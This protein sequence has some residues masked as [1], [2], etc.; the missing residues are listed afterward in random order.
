MLQ[1]RIAHPEQQAGDQGYHHHDH[2]AFQV[3]AVPDM[4][5]FA[6]YRAGYQ[7]KRFKGIE[8]GMQECERTAFAEGRPDPFY[9]LSNTFIASHNHKIYPLLQNILDLYLGR[10]DEFTKGQIFGY[11]FIDA[12]FPF[13]LCLRQVWP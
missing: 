5:P 3:V 7:E 9:D 6:G 8:C 2:D 12:S 4:G 10:T 1:S 11:N 13:C